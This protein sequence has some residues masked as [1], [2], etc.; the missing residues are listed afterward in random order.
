MYQQHTSPTDSLR[1]QTNSFVSN[2]DAKLHIDIPQFSYKDTPTP[3]ESESSGSSVDYGTYT[4]YESK[5]SRTSPLAYRNDEEQ[6]MITEYHGSSHYNGNA[7]GPNIYSNQLR[8]YPFDPKEMSHDNKV[9]SATSKKLTSICQVCGDQAPEHI[10]YG[11]VSC[12]SC[13][14]FFRR[15][16]SKSNSY[17][18]PGNRQCSIVVTTRKNCQYCRY[19]ACLRAGMRPTWVLTDKEKKDRT[20]SKTQDLETANT[21][22]RQAFKAFAYKYLKC[23][24]KMNGKRIKDGNTS[25]G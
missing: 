4:G 21:L 20:K 8:S 17:V 19:Q 2:K 7:N 12:F 11:S 1:N 22:Q 5:K 10:H 23:I 9:G 13:R 15:S 14:A 16:V 18:C 25:V 3:P 6:G 24:Q